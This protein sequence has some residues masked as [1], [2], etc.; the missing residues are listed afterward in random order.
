[1][2][3]SSFS[4]PR[5]QHL[6]RCSSTGHPALLS[7]DELLRSAVSLISNSVLSDDQWLQTSLPIKDCGLGIRR[8]SSLATPAF[9]AS[10]LPLQSRILV[11]YCSFTSDSVIQACLISSWFQS[12]GPPPDPLPIKQ[13]FY[14]RPC[15]CLICSPTS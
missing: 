11:S 14:D 15:R 9:L 5:V 8:V 6:I 4:A 3:R 12:F 1:L 2:L 10:T 13:C 7:F